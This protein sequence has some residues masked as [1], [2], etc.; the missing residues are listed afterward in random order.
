MIRIPSPVCF[1]SIVL[2]SLDKG[3][4]TSASMNAPPSPVVAAEHENRYGAT[5]EDT[6]QEDPV[7]QAEV[8]TTDPDDDKSF[9][10]AEE[11][12]ADDDDKEATKLVIIASSTN[13]GD[14]DV[15]EEERNAIRYAILSRL[16]LILTKLL[17][18]SD[19]KCLTCFYNLLGKFEELKL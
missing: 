18:I 5:K 9:V 6:R 17:N 19:G 2:D 1:E 7:P 16:Y 4:N 14:R 8:Q 11:P 3:T 15:D 12:V 10:D 13:E